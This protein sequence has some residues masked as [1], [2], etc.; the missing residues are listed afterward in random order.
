MHRNPHLKPTVSV[1]ITL[2]VFAVAGA[3]KPSQSVQ[4]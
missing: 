2:T 4:I 1:E 3:S